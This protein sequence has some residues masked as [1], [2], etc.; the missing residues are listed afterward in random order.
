M[1]FK[2]V[3]D[4]IHDLYGAQDFVPL[5]VP[6]FIG[7]EKNTSTSVLKQHLFLQ[8]VNSLIDLKKIQ[9]SIQDVKEQLCV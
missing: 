4:F 8:L 7:N 3:T 9:P 5:A 6:V 1:E 2:K